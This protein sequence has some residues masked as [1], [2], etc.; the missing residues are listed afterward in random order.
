MSYLEAVEAL[1]QDAVAAGQFSG[2]PG[3][4]RPFSFKP[5]EGL[6]GDDWLAFKVLQ[7]GGLLPEF[8]NIGREVE[9]L[10]NE[11]TELDRRHAA[12]AATAMDSDA[13]D[14]SWPVILQIRARF[15]ETARRLRITQ[16]KFN[17]EAPGHRSQRAPIWV[18]YRLER[19]DL[20]LACPID[21]RPGTR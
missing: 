10:E 9:T 2:L 20:R 4:G 21:A 14:V 16:E 18:E 6:A 1:L 8:L 17:W 11:L 7:N 3:E 19:L 5:H 15:E 12:L 13:W